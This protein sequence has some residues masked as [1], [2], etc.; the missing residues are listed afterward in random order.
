MSKYQSGSKYNEPRK[1]NTGAYMRGIGCLMML[2]VPVFSYALG[3]ELV[4]NNIGYGVI[5]KD[6]FGF[7]K[8]PEGIANSGLAP[9]ARQLAS[10]P[11]L[12]AIL[13]F[14]ALGILVLGGVIA[15]MYGYIYQ[16]ATPNRYGPMD[17]PPPRVKTKKYKR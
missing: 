16:I 9:I 2:V 12:P 3:K 15:I 10:V 8:I 14:T 13:V 17:V 7:M 6:W 11:G 4:K 1:D 5:P